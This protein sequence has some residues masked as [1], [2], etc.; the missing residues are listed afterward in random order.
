MNENRPESLFRL[1]LEILLISQREDVL[2]RVQQKVAQNDFTFLHVGGLGELKERPADLERA[3]V[4]L[5]SQENAEHV[6][7]FS[8]RIEQ[9]LERFPFA[10]IVT[11]MQEA[12]LKESFA[13]TQNERVIPLLKRISLN[14]LSW[15]IFV[16]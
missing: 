10:T 2:L 16:F 13:G 6:G 3:A 4:V 7:A 14:L 1:R 15:S 9:L 12:S 8:E 5:V 11:V